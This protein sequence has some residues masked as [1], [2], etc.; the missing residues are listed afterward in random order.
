MVKLTKN[1]LTHS[2]FYQFM[3]Q[4]QR[5]W[6]AAKTSLG[7]PTLV[8]F[9]ALILVRITSLSLYP[10]MDMTEGR[11][12]EIGRQM[13]SRNDWITPWIDAGVPFWGKPPLSFWMSALGIKLFGVNE[14][15]VRIPHFFAAFLV[16]A[17][18]YDWAKRTRINPFYVSIILGTSILFVIS[19]GAVMT[20]MALCLGST[21]SIRGFWLSLRGVEARR[22]SE[23]ALFFTGLGLMLLAK[24]P[25]GW[26]LV[27]LPIGLWTLAS[28]SI[29]E[30]WR[31]IAWI[32]G[33]SLAI[34]MALPWYLLAEQQTPG[35]LHYFFYGEHW[36]RF[37]VSGWKGDLY[38]KAHVASR[39][40][41]WLHFLLASLPWSLILPIAAWRYKLL[42]F[43]KSQTEPAQLSM[44]LL[45]AGLSPCLFFTMSSNIIWTYTLPG[46]PA[47]AL[48]MGMYLQ[49]AEQMLSQKILL[50]G[51][52]ISCL[53]FIGLVGGLTLSQAS[54]LKSAAAIVKLYKQQHNPQT[55]LF[56]GTRPMS[57]MFYS[58]GQALSVNNLNEVAALTAGKPAYIAVKK[59]E[60]INLKTP[61]LTAIGDAGDYRLY[62]TGQ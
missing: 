16:V 41:V 35:F 52:A 32:K 40:T 10:L 22:K 56:L 12:G 28:S 5:F 2:I 11:Y 24:G 8:I 23:Q 21:L 44:Y 17:I 49:R 34:L 42:S 9:S 37:T 19:S 46:F 3:V 13:A 25:V 6:Q 51:T 26:I 29:K 60:L 30:T 1:Y 48:L 53:I 15:A 38:G 18:C 20:D 59:A 47:L 27:L 33:T 50:I 39:G 45:L 36:Q 62:L 43:N 7:T 57:A 31:G 54:D 61:H 14:F 58:Q 55:L 4:I